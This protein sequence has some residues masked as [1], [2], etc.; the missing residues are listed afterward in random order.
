MNEDSK[1]DLPIIQLISF[2]KLLR[3]YDVM[4]QSDNKMAQ[5]IIDA[6]KPYPELRAGF[7]D[8]ALLEK[9]KDVIN[10][11]LQDI[12]SEVLTNNEIKA[13]SLPY[14]NIIFN[15]SKRFKKILKDAGGDDFLPQMRNLPE[16]QMYIVA[17]TVI[18]NFHYG[19]N[20]DF[21]RPFFYR[22]KTV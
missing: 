10:I 17:C 5:R 16:H 19:F 2:D 13:A 9:H 6:A 15:S 8:V 21:K 3:Q 18:L 20:F 1:I 12:F 22:I 14:D 4:A 7:N 11:I